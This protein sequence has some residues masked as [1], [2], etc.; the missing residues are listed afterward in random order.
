FTR[1]IEGGVECGPN[2]VLALAREGYRKTDVNL[3]D[4]Y[5][6]LSYRGFQKLALKYWRTGM[7]EMWRSISKRAFV[8]ALRRLV[9]EIRSE[10]LQ[11]APSGVRAQALGRDGELVDDF[12]FLEGPRIVN[13]CNA[14]SPA[15]TASLN[16]GNLIVDRLTS[17][18]N[19]VTIARGA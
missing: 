19:P 15:A 16:I 5:E 11:A 12:L 13:V 3:R 14:P 2:A 7:G 10:H 17:Q 4:L 6:S 9:P 18:V 1:L 8:K